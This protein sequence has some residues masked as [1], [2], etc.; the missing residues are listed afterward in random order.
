[1]SY[2]ISPDLEMGPVALKVSNLDRSLDYYMNVIGLK[3]LS[4]EHKRAELSVEDSAVLVELIEI[5]DAVITPERTTTGLY[6]FAILLPDRVSLGLSLSHLI[7]QGEKIGQADHLVSEALYLSDPD[8]NGIEIYRDRSR[9]QWQMQP[10]GQVIMAT[11][12]IDWEGLLAEAQH[13]GRQWSGLPAGTKIGHVHLHVGDLEVA[14]EFYCGL[15]GF[16]LTANMARW[17]AIFVSAGG[18][19]HH[20][21]LNIWA[22][23]GA[24]EPGSNAT[25]LKFFTVGLPDSASLHELIERIEAAGIK[26]LQQDQAYE[27]KDPFGTA[28]RFVSKDAVRLN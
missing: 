8:G 19:H 21:G 4:H 24:P 11:D 22:G 13:S 15:L 20:L 1:M 16:E 9:D 25:G 10:D 2:V 28:I 3:L 7:E 26:V 14:R 18:Y 5:D 27:V 6:H 12:P 23:Q 17:G